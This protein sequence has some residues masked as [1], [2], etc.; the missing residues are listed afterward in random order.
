MGEAETLAAA[1]E[2]NAFAIVD[3]AEARAV[4]KSYGIKTRTETLFLLFRLLA[5]KRIET[6]E[7][8]RILDNLVESGLYL[9]SHTYIRA[10]QKIR[11]ESIKQRQVR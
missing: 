2:L 3:E 6:S 4:A 11:S 7:C 1:N 5:L 10:K 9:D 8:E